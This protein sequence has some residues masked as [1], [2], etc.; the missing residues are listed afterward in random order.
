MWLPQ[1]ADWA[2][3]A[4]LFNAPTD[5]A[6]NGPRAGRDIGHKRSALQV[7]AV[8]TSAAPLNGCRFLCG[9]PGKG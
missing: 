7:I 9:L 4:S 6:L 8:N 1:P 5:I 3:G 2:D